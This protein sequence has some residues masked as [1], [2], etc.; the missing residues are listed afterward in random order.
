[1]ISTAGTIK[2]GQK[3]FSRPPNSVLLFLYLD[4]FQ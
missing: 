4:Q 1:M 3:Q 2:L